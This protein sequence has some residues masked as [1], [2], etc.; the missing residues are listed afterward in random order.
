MII[1]LMLLSPQNLKDKILADGCNSIIFGKSRG[2]DLFLVGGYIR[3]ALRGIS[4]ADRDFVMTGD[5][6][7]FVS[8]IKTILPG[9]LIEFKKGKMIRLSLKKGITLD[10]S[11]LQGSLKEDLSMRD[12]TVNA[13]AWSSDHGLVDPYNGLK[14]L[15]KG[16][17][18]TLS[19]K[20]LISDPLR[21]IRAYRFAAELNGSI[22]NGTR[23]LI[24]KLH[25]MVET[26]SPERITSELFNILNFDK[27]ARY[28][29]MALSDNLLQTV[30]PISEN[31]L[32]RNIKAISNL[33]EKLKKFPL[34]VKSQLKNLFS[35]NLTFIGLLRLELLLWQNS[36]F[37][38]LSLPK[39]QL[40]NK[41]IKRI[42][43]AHRG[44]MGFE[45]RN[46]FDFFYETKESSMDVLIIED[47]P[48]L[49]EDYE[50]F[51]SIWKKGVIDSYEIS[52]ISEIKGPVIGQLIKRAKKAEFQREI[53]SKK[54]AVNFV[55]DIVHN[56]S[57]K[58]FQR[59]ADHHTKE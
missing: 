35:Q 59:S 13:M 34:K 10:I 22:D 40:S 7:T 43:L 21:L 3:D 19:E 33:E 20:N 42:T 11:R 17:I 55:R 24:K 6:R 41:V 57:S 23:K 50:R 32:G 49:L 9:T 29:R 47:R 26:T 58:N 46:L 31:V 45:D 52:R 25:A 28:L 18:R 56:I 54:E 8:R 2:R 30:I 4:S 37:S 36:P 51:V 1:L 39:L 53:K 27:P 38:S 44:M 16:I 15:R 14:D 12:F 48:D 5:V